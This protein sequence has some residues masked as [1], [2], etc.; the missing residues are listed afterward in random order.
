MAY[1]LGAGELSTLRRQAHW[2][3]QI[4]RV[5][6]LGGGLPLLFTSSDRP[7]V[8]RGEVYRP[9]AGERYDEETEGAAAVGSAQLIGAL[10]PTT[11][12]S[13]DILRGVY[14]NARV[15]AY[16][17]D[18]RHGKRYRHDVWYIDELTHDG[19]TWSATL[20]TSAKFL[21][22]TVGDIY[23][24]LCPAVLGDQRCGAT[25]TPVDMTVSAV[26][27]SQLEFD[28]ATTTSYA[29]GWFRFGVVEWLSG[30]NVGTKQ[31][32]RAS[33]QSGRF[34]LSFPTRFPIR[35]GDTFRATPGCDKLA[36]TCRDKFAN[37]LNYRGNERQKNSK[38]L[39]LSR[40]TA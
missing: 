18:W 36:T 9:T 10:S 40:G 12:T 14:D 32:V 27:D 4:F 30:S 19:R 13:L 31:R 38:Q 26:L 34:T 8:Y 11:I 5:T 17:F 21:Q 24:S 25:V 7:Q 29:T 2:R 20:T 6:R 3:C 35:V 23:S 33:V 28:Q 22:R 16:E 1:P 39:I 37:L 15:D